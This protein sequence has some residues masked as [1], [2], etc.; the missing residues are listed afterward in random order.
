M[1]VSKKESIPVKPAGHKAVR[2]STIQQEEIYNWAKKSALHRMYYS[3]VCSLHIVNRHCILVFEAEYLSSVFVN[4]WCISVQ[5]IEVKSLPKWKYNW[6]AVK[7]W[8]ILRLQVDG[9]A[10]RSKLS[11]DKWLVTHDVWPILFENVRS[12]ALTICEIHGF[13]DIY[14]NHQ[15][16][17]QPVTEVLV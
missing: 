16:V 1:L 3:A 11:Q 6:P 15:W 14:T 12:L 5:G 4:L 8:Q 2:L 13:E 7:I 10:R 9:L 17:N